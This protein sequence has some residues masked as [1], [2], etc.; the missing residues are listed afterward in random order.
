MS[1]RA[2]QSL[3]RAKKFLLLAAGS[4]A[5]AGPMHHRHHIG[6]R[7][8]A[9]GPCSVICSDPATLAGERTAIANDSR[10]KIRCSLCQPCA[11]G[12]VGGGRRNRGGSSPGR[13]S[14]SCVTVMSLI[15]QAY[16]EYADGRQTFPSS[17]PIEGGPAWINSES[18]SIEA[19][20]EGA[21]EQALMKGPMLQ[22]LLNQRFKLKVHSESKQAPIYALSVAKGG[23]KFQPANPVSCVPFDTNLSPP[24][25]QFCG[26]PKRGDPGLH[27]IGATMSDLCKILSAPEISDRPVVDKT[28]LTGMF[29]VQLPTI[30]ELTG[31]TRGPLRDTHTGA[32]DSVPI[33]QA[34][35]GDSRFDGMRAAIEKLGLSLAPAKGPSRFLVIDQVERPSDN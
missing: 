18:Y 12:A 3:N 25:P 15:R 4:A 26:Q 32:A 11:A 20:A 23:P 16:I 17:L 2:V 29:D 9:S 19:T 6:L 31:I 13:L 1:N 5:F 33:D 34:A 14:E 35:P 21:P 10:A 30:G 22:A 27:L 7:P 28:G 24:Y 8:C